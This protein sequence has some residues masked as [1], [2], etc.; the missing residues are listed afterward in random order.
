M[1]RKTIP[2]KRIASIRVSNVDKKSVEDEL[3]VRLCNYTDV[4]YRDSVDPSQEFMWATASRAQV[5]AF[6]LK[7][8]DVV[9]TKDSESADDIGIPTHVASSAPDLV[10]GY[11]LALLRPLSEAV[12]GRFLFWCM[13]SASMRSQFEVSATGI[14]RFGLRTDAIGDTTLQLPPLHVQ[15]AIADYLDAET[16]RIDALIEKKWRMLHVLEERRRSYLL[17]LLV[18]SGERQRNL[19]WLG[20][21]PEDWPLVKIGVVAD[22]YAGTTFPHSYQ[23]Q[24]EGDLPFIKVGDLWSNEAGTNIDNAANWITHS[25]AQELRGTIVPRGSILYARVGEALRLNP[26]RLVTRPS[27][28]D[29][30]VRAIHFRHGDGRYWAELLTQLDLAQLSNPGPVPSVSEGQ[31]ATA[32]VP[33]PPLQE[34][35][36]IADALAGERKVRTKLHASVVEQIELL[37]EHRQALITAAV[38]GQLQIPGAKHGTGRTRI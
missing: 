28:I 21:V 33:M 18:S 32:R 15:Q 17:N 4:Y 16:A 29:D 36:R 24:S 14:T 25:T 22:F 2:L 26:R 6:N 38:T 37:I 13:S 3:P 27:V 23:G 9:I 12:R 1:S 31:V 10:C 8:G 20:N 30:N 11:H 7:A 5:S 34:Q 19:E 35:T